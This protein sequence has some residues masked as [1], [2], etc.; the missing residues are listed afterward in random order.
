MTRHNQRRNEKKKGW[1]I[2]AAIAAAAVVVVVLFAT[3]TFGGGRA[4]LFAVDEKASD[5]SVQ[6]VS[7]EELRAQ[8]QEAVDKSMFSFKINSE[9]VFADGGAEG[10][11][12]IGN[13]ETNAYPMK[14]EI[15]LDKTDE[16]V[17]ATEGI[18]PGQSIREDKLDTPLVKGVYPATATFYA[19]DENGQEILGQVMA[20]LTITVES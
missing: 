12:K 4:A 6:N 2:A 7:Q 18:L 20:A 15:R 1:I 16:M 9:P 17:Y 8:L 13:P 11:L 10:E 19:Y 14:V 3:G 5:G